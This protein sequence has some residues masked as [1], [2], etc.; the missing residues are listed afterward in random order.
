MTY[1]NPGLTQLGGKLRKPPRVGAAV[2]AV[3]RQSIVSGDFADSQLLP[4]E[5]ELLAT[6]Q[7]SRQSIRE[8]MRILETEGLVTVRRGN[9]GGAVVHAPR[10]DTA[11][12]MLGLVLENQGTTL[13]DLAAT[14]GSLE[15][16]CAALC[17]Q[18]GDRAEA[19]VP[20]LERH[21]ASLS[22]LPAD[23]QV[24]FPGLAR[25]FHRHLVELCG[26]DTLVLIFGTLEMLWS[27]QARPRPA[28]ATAPRHDSPRSRAAVLMAHA[29]ITDL[30]RS[31]DA[32]RARRAASQHLTDSREYT[33][34][35]EQDLVVSGAA[36][37]PDMRA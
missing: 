35:C 34:P 10:P 3:L 9:V 12:Y 24:T 17:A 22:E 6:F 16:D 36:L 5:D 26:C 23:D 7:V 27:A 37:R 18:R 15:P 14:L 1:D 31:G 29:G 32:D 28:Q 11:A 13:G 19:V 20:L 2:A 4:K 25:Q 8:A 33:V 30:I 21:N